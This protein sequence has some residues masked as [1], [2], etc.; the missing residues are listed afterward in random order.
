MLQSA[1]Q[2]AGIDQ[3]KEKLL[4]R[5][6]GNERA[7]RKY[8][9][10][11]RERV[12]EAYRLWLKPASVVEKRILEALDEV[13]TAA[14]NR[15]GLDARLLSRVHALVNPASAQAESGLREDPGAA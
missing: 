11:S 1:I 10:K 8:E 9:Q 2:F 3:R 14:R 6:K 13:D 7:R 12:L 15:S 5:L 4:A